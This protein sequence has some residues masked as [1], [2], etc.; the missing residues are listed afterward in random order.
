MLYQ[1]AF[2]HCQVYDQLGIP[3]E[4][5]QMRSYAPQPVTLKTSK[6]SDGNLAKDEDLKTIISIPSII[7][8]FQLPSIILLNIS[9]ALLAVTRKTEVRL[10]KL[11]YIQDRNYSRD[12]RPNISTLK[13]IYPKYLN[14]ILFNLA[15]S[16]TQPRNTTLGN[17][18]HSAQLYQEE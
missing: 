5:V 18:S 12:H 15:I 4:A 14:I 9:L 11:S 1:L 3:Q 13:I 2:P 16:N 8:Y 7:I 10:T 6:I 17:Q